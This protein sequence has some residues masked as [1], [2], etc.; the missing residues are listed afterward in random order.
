MS[1]DQTYST[2]S[3]VTIT[4]TEMSIGV[5]GGTTV[6]LPLSRTDLGLFMIELDG[7]ANMIKGD[8]YLLQIYKTVRSG[9]TRRL[10]EAIRLRGPQ[11]QVFAYPWIPLT[12]WDV[13]MTRISATSRAWDWCINRLT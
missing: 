1:L 7:I 5:T 6:G 10:F 12:G 13:T 4:N 8:E 3:A 9:G 2:G 11:T